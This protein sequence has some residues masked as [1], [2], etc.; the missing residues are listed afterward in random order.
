MPEITST[1]LIPEGTHLIAIIGAE[2]AKDFDNK[3]IEGT[4]G[5]Y[6]E[7]KFSTGDN[8]VCTH[9]LWTKSN[10]FK[11]LCEDV[12]ADLS[13]PICP[14]LTGKR[15]WGIFNS[16]C[17][18]VGSSKCDNPLHMPM[19]DEGKSLH[20]PKE[21]LGKTITIASITPT[22]QA[23]LDL[24]KKIIEETMKKPLSSLN[25]KNNP[26]QE[27]PKDDSWDDL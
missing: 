11:K 17:E 6:I 3:R 9:A 21:A 13:K 7:I 2:T 16:R 26:T 4:E 22:Q 23:K 20:I 14:E 5:Y 27:A 19:P 24:G 18:F 15:L 12:E 10:D 8:K 1:I 25:Q